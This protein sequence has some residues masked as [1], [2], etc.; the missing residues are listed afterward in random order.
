VRAGGKN[1]FRQLPAP[2][3][4][5]SGRGPTDPAAQFS[6]SGRMRSTVV[7]GRSKTT[8]TSVNDDW[9][10]PGRVRRHQGIDHALETRCPSQPHLPCCR[11]LERHTRVCVS[12]DL[13]CS[14]GIRLLHSGLSAEEELLAEGRCSLLLPPPALY[15]LRN[16]GSTIACQAPC[17]H[18]RT[19][20]G[21]H[22]EM[23]KS[24]EF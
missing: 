4:S 2:L 13:V 20:Q 24:V 22:Q 14:S 19:A 16:A 5:L 1:L 7:V 9:K 23:Y 18:T 3:P 15:N 11:M 21:A 10:H 8:P 12:V 17:A 6:P